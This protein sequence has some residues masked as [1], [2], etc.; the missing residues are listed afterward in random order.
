M[1]ILSSL[2]RMSI[3]HES[4]TCA[5]SFKRLKPAS[6]QPQVAACSKSLG[7]SDMEIEGITKP[8]TCGPR[9]LS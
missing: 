2:A 6:A 5:I 9:S 4:W 8:E 3:M 1:S 7:I